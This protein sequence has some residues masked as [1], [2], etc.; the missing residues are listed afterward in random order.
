VRDGTL[1][2]LVIK[3]FFYPPPSSTFSIDL[4]F[5]CRDVAIIAGGDQ[6]LSPVIPDETLA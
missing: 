5:G 1:S 2:M 4:F 3:I 6:I